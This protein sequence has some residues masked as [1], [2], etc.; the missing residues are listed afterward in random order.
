MGRLKALV[1]AIGAKASFGIGKGSVQSNG[2][3]ADEEHTTKGALEYVQ[4]PWMTHIRLSESSFR[5][6]L[7]VS[8]PAQ[9]PQIT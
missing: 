1:T 9:S 3:S 2:L 5:K 8:V 7:S 6:D 4:S